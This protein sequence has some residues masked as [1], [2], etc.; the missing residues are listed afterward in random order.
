MHSIVDL[1]FLRLPRTRPRP[2]S[3]ILPTKEAIMKDA[4]RSGS[5]PVFASLS[6]ALPNPPFD[7]TFAIIYP[8]LQIFHLNVLIPF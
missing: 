5:R 6:I 1:L 8:A 3:F 2:P 4:L 7:A